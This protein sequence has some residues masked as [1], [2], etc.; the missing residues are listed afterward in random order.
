MKAADKVYR[1]LAFL[2]ILTLVV[3]IILLSRLWYLQ[4]LAG[5]KYADLAERNRIRRVAIEAPRGIIY[6]RQGIVLVDNRP[7]LAV[8]ILPKVYENNKSIVTG[9]SQILQMSPEE[10]ESK[11]KEKSID[12]FSPRTIKEDVSEEAIAFIKEHQTDFP[13]VGIKVNSI[14]SYHFESLAAH[15][16]GYLGEVSEKEL[17]DS[18]YREYDLGDI[19]GKTGIEY[20]YEPFLR[21]EK[22]N[23]QLEINAVGRPLRV[24]NS[25]SPEPG[26]NVVI[27]I[28]KNIQQTA[29]DTLADAIHKARMGKHKSA[30]AGAAIVL[31]PRNG[32]VLAMASYPSYEPS[33]F[34]GGISANIWQALNSKESNYPLHSRAFMSSYPPGS[35]FKP[36][37]GLAALAENLT[38]KKT[39]FFCAGSWAKMGRKWLKYCWKK[40]GHGRVSF[41]QGIVVSCD[42]V[43][44]ELGYKFYKQGGELLQEWSRH[45]G[46]GAPTGIDLPS[47]TSGRVPDKAW[48]KTYFKDRRRQAWVPGDTVNMAIGQG[49]LLV[50]PLQL[51]NAY[52]AIANGGIIY[53]PHLVKSISTYDGKEVIHYNPKENGRLPLSKAAISVMQQGLE[54]VT[55]RGTAASAF[56][57]FPIPVAGKTGTAE[58]AGKDDLAWFVGYAPANEPQYV[59]LVMVEQGGHGGSTAA[60][61]VRRILGEIYH[62]NPEQISSPEVVDFSR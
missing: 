18:K 25:H 21:G 13:G 26:N 62:L 53:K 57:G 44:Y 19:V 11:M 37:T 9:L 22:G 15:I 2:G 32:E 7:G 14:R 24:L 8:T 27:T 43:F 10:I 51:A 4:V 42:V 46:L 29:E 12:P 36:I 28:D 45:F 61:A 55:T 31:D 39:T 60:P 47:E 6:D 20:Q 17:E 1:R 58:V 54:M 59:V 48:K 23:Q 3:F 34:V 16:L 41:V 35:T 5:D 30:N 50:T 38:S 49:D 52:A 56:A 33:L 40:S